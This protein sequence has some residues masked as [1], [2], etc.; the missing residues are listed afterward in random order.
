M[1]RDIEVRSMKVLIGFLSLV[2]AL[3][4]MS[5]LLSSVNKKSQNSEERT[6]DFIIGIVSFIVLVVIASMTASGILTF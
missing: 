4:S 6:T 1:L 3:V 2:L 5:G